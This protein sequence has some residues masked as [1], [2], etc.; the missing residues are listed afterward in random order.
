VHSWYLLEL[1]P[2]PWTAPQIGTGRKGGRSYVQAY[3]NPELHTFQQ[4]VKEEFETHYPDVTPMS[5]PIDLEFFFW[6]ELPD[7]LSVN[8]VKVRKH[9]ADVTNLQKALEDALQGVLFDN[10]R[11]VRAIRS[12]IIEQDFETD[13][14]ILVGIHQHRSSDAAVTAR[15]VAARLLD[16]RIEAHAIPI[17]SGE[18]LF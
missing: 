10:D 13:P 14:L 2:I 6:R 11:N 4:A 5:G 18:D 3:K 8:N 16:E 7:Y 15:K 1:N 9:Q 17:R 12:Q